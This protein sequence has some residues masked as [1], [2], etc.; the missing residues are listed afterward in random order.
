MLKKAA[1]LFG[2]VFLAIGVLGFLPFLQFGE[3]AGGAPLLLGLFAVNAIHNI[4]HLASGA[5]ALAASS[6]TSYARL[7]FKIFGVVYALVTVLGFL[8]GGV[9]LGIL[10]INL[11]DNILH[12][13]IAAASLYLGFGYKGHEAKETKATA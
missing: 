9:L 2:V 7:Y 1:L 12:L 11:F 6:S 5:A 10:P 3:T 13:V 8:S 4:I